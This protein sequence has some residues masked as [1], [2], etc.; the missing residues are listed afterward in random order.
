MLRCFSAST[1]QG[2]DATGDVFER[3]YKELR[4]SLEWVRNEKKVVCGLG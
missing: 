1:V 2:E 3:R 4:Q